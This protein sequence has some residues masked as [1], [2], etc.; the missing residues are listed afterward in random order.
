MLFSVTL[1]SQNVDDV[2][3]LVVSG[4]R[5]LSHVRKFKSFD[6]ENEPQ[7][8]VLTLSSPTWTPSLRLLSWRA[9]TDE[10]RSEETPVFGYYIRTVCVTVMSRMMPG[11]S[12]VRL[13]ESEWLHGPGVNFNNQLAVLGSAHPLSDS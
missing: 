2:P 11:T 7:A 13:G 12:C 3:V 9:L 8:G 6:T 5:S 4:T 1:E 10:S